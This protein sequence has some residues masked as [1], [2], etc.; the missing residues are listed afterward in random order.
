MDA[1]AKDQ[2]VFLL[3]GHSTF[4]NRGCE[5]LVRSTC[6]FLREQD[7]SSRILVPSSD[8]MADA[9]QWPGHARMGISFVDVPTPTTTS[10][11]IRKLWRIASKGGR[12][13]PFA[14]SFQRPVHSTLDSAHA[15]ISIGGDVYSTDYGLDSLREIM[16]VDAL[17]MQKGLPTFLWGA[18]VGPIDAATGVVP[19]L[20]EHLNRLDGIS[21]REEISLEYLSRLGVRQPSR[22]WDGAFWLEP[23]ATGVEHLRGEPGRRL[24]GL[25]VSPLIDRFRQDRTPFVKMLA[26]AVRRL[27]AEGPFTVLLIPHVTSRTADKSNCDFKLLSD[28]LSA[29]E[30]A[31][32]V[33]LVPDTLN[34]SQL[35]HI[36]SE[37]DLFVGARTH[38]TIAAYSTGVPTLSISYS[39]KS[40]GLC[41]DLFGTDRYLLE[42]RALD[43]NSLL[44]A[45]NRVSADSVAIKAK[46][47]GAWRREQRQFVEAFSRRVVASA[48][49]SRRQAL[50]ERRS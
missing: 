48:V 25:N 19:I 40:R 41:Q 8:P 15:V 11:A 9:R 35:K 29:L 18:S 33:H 45:V 31:A 44:D 7:P 30:P 16:A 17:A 36:I 2:P 6:M 50:R 13:M 42:A 27:V 38:S 22:V 24:L 34:A 28:V 46:L 21:V 20:I 4:A 14:P 32:H 39:V 10:R 3:T 49:G 12:A 1:M 43:P 23:D 5:A 26:E 37:C 47:G